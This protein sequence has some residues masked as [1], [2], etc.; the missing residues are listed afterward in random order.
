MNISIIKYNHNIK[1]TINNINRNFQMIILMALS[2]HNN[3]HYIKYW[4]YTQKSWKFIL[5]C[6]LLN[7]I[8]NI[9]MCVR[10]QQ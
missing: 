10:T 7:N 3:Q 6:L 9:N 1:H 2:T 4:K 8:K 5:I